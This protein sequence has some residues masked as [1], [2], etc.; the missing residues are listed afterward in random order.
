VT[1]H[2]FTVPLGGNAMANVNLEAR[3]PLT[4]AFQIVPFYDGGNVFRRIGDLFGR[5]TQQGG[6]T[7]SANLRAQWSNTVGL[8]LRIKTPIGGAL[9]VDYGFLLDP[10]A[11]LIPQS[12]GGTAIFRLKRGQVHFRFTQSF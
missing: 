6:D 10:P 8:G 5:S 11:F 1:L 7:T 12:D 2:P 4:K 3:V 9:S